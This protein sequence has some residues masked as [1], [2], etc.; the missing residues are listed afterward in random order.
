MT[1]RSYTQ[2]ITLFCSYD[3]F[4]LLKVRSPEF[5][6]E[7]HLILFGNKYF[8]T[9]SFKSVEKLEVDFWLAKT[10]SRFFSCYQGSP[11][12]A[13]W[14][15]CMSWTALDESPSDNTDLWS[16]ERKDES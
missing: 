6:S 7:K 1:E 11:R 3:A 15:C 12:G 13:S 10:W 5:I 9:L 14:P 16:G 8:K 4:I 2:R